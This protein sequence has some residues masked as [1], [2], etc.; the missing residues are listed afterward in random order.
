M[1]L[2]IGQS[3]SVLNRLVAARRATG[4]VLANLNVRGL[5]SR[6]FSVA[7]PEAAVQEG[8]LRH[9]EGLVAEAKRVVNRNWELL[10][11]ARIRAYSARIGTLA[12]TD[13]SRIAWLEQGLIRR[14]GLN[15]TKVDSGEG[16]VRAAL[17]V[18]AGV[19]IGAVPGMPG[20]P[21]HALAAGRA[22][23]AP[24]VAMLLRM[25]VLDAEREW[26]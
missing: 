7:A 23:V 21:D 1:Q 6:R 26:E 14:S 22:G 24:T 8:L 9:A 3:E 20:F 25:M 13:Q 12:G 15:S 18:S 2:A 16:L 4:L 10:S 19:E 11:Q 17:A 5:P